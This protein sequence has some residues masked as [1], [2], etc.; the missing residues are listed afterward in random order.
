MRVPSFVE[1]QGRN[2]SYGEVK[3]AREITD[4]LTSDGE[5]KEGSF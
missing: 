2:L 5:R 1:V 4:K 3:N